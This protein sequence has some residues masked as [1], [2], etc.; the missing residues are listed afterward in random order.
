M[1]P[2]ELSEL[3]WPAI[4]IVGGLTVNVLGW[5]VVHHLTKRREIQRDRRVKAE[6]REAQAQAKRDA[7]IV[8][9]AESRILKKCIAP[10]GFERGRVWIMRV[11]AFGPWV[12]AGTNDFCNQF[13]NSFQAEYLDAFESLLNRGF[14]RQESGDLYVLTSIGFQR[15]NEENEGI[16]PNRP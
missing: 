2:F 16:A 1:I 14:F 7:M 3:N 4:G 8:T 13:D 12:R 5:F 10:E 11:D 6:G 9:D 15:A